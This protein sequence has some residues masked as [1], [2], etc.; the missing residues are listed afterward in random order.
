[1]AN[2]HHHKKLRAEVRARMTRT[3]ESYQTALQR[4][5]AKRNEIL[6]KVDLIPFRFFGLSM[7]LVTSERSEVQ[8]VA[9]LGAAPSSGGRFALPRAIWLRPRGVN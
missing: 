6:P 4:I 2:R 8:S 7:T 5:S 3:G 1:M 9:V